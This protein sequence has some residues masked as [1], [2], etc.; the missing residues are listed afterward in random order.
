MNVLGLGPGAQVIILQALSAYAAIASAYCFARPVL[1]GQAMLLSKTILSGVK[2]DD[3]RFKSLLAT[4]N[5]T[6]QERSKADQPLDHRSNKWGV[7]LLV[8]S[9]LLLSGA[10]ALQVATDPS[11]SRSEAAAAAGTKPPPGSNP[12]SGASK[13]K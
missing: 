1:R 4:A 13:T 7:G 12:G 2:S 9:V 6:L 3:D 8:A 10:V 11:F 5:A